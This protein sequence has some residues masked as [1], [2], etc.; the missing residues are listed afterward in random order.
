MLSAE[1]DMSQVNEMEVQE[2]A[3]FHFSQP[4]VDKTVLDEQ[5][6]KGGIPMP[7]HQSTVL[8]VQP[9]PEVND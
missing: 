6:I 3:V 9:Q 8:E 7:Q 2:S 4:Y 1:T 5:T